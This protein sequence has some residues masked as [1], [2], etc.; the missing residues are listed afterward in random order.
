[1]TN[2]LS[3]PGKDSS[4]ATMCSSDSKAGS[5]GQLLDLISGFL[6]STGRP[7]KVSTGSTMFE[8]ND[9]EL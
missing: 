4:F 9:T 2:L 3:V 7:S 1:M 5:D 8:A 6:Q